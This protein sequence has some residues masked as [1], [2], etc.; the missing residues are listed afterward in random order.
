MLEIVE[1]C[2]VLQIA[3]VYIHTLQKRIICFIHFA[4]FVLSCSS[5][6]VCYGIAVLRRQAHAYFQFDKLGK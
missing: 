2:N 4:L 5:D 1:M 6:A 3:K